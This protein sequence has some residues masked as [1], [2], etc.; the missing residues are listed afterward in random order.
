MLLPLVRHSI[1]I[2]STFSFSA[3]LEIIDFGLLSNWWSSFLFELRP[4]LNFNLFFRSSWK[5]WYWCFESSMFISHVRQDSMF[6]LVISF[7][8][9]KKCKCSFDYLIYFSSRWVNKFKSFS[10]FRL[11]AFEKLLQY[12][13]ESLILVSRSAHDFSSLCIFLV[14]VWKTLTLNFWV[15]VVGISSPAREFNSDLH[16][17]SSAKQWQCYSE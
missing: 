12:T 11:G 7:Y 14:L 6:F 3:F 1:S 9:L 15:F 2:N 16:L 13:F 10:M 4:E 8:L 17:F 5:L